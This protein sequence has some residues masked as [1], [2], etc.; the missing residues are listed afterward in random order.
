M[1]NAIC[2]YLNEDE[3]RVVA[4]TGKAAN[5]IYGQTYHSL[6]GINDRT[7]GYVD[8]RGASLKN[9]QDTLK[10]VKYLILDEYSMV[11]AESFAL[12]DFKYIFL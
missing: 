8:L 11:G 9:L 5:N 3:Y 1:V 2:T 12:I 4:P 6:L 10:G 7:A